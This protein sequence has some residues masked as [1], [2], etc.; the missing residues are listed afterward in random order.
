MID[1]VQRKGYRV[2]DEICL[3]GCFDSIDARLCDPPLSS[4]ILRDHEVGARG[5]ELLEEM[6][7]RPDFPQYNLV[8]PINGVR[9]RASTAA[10]NGQDMEV[11]RARQIIRERACMGVTVDQIVAELKVSRSTFEKRF[12]ALTGHSPAQEIRE[13]RLE[14]A[15]EYL[16]T[17]DLPLTKVAPLVGFMDRRAFMVFFKRESGMTPGAFRDAHK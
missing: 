15:R 2:P 13:V 10:N 3:L 4:V 12:S 16:L 6:M 11:L 7:R 17:T 1:Y 5:M 9:M 8:M 14:K